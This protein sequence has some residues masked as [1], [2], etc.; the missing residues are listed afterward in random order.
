[1]AGKPLNKKNLEALGA[2]AQPANAQQL[3]LS[4]AIP[5]G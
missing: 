2:E 4:F 5:C 3:R 1:M